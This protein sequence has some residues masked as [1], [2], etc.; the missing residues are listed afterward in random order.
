M[1]DEIQT[2][3]LVLRP[4][5][6]ADAVVLTRLI[7][8]PRIY[9]NVGRIPPGQPVE[10]TRRIQRER[11]VANAAGKS[12]GFCAYLGDE[13]VGMAGGGE[14]PDT[15]LIDFGYWIAPDHW[16]KG[17]V[18]E[19]GAAVLHWFVHNQERREMTAGYFPD[20][21][22]SGRVLEKLGFR[23]SGE[24]RYFCLGREMEVDCIEMYWPASADVFN[25]YLQDTP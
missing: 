20:N 15:G 22:G 17:F 21:P 13:L 4:Y 18:T 24:S 5:R 11:A 1:T 3:R 6:D 9:R 7:N 2:S 19:A 10:E 25:A 12:A 14:S 8:D 16:G 23:K